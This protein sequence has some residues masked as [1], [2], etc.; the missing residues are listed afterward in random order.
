MLGP[1]STAEEAMTRRMISEAVPPIW[2]PALAPPMLYIAG[3]DHGPL[4]FL[5]VRQLIGPRPPVPP[6][7]KANF[8]TLG[9]MIMQSAFAT[10]PD[11]M[12]LLLSIACNTE[13][14]LRRVCSSLDLSAAHIGKANK[15]SVDMSK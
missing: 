14:A 1:A 7:P 11:G 13:A 8:F 4:K 2:K 10:T 9:R 6:T 3:A 12:S 15:A 5:P